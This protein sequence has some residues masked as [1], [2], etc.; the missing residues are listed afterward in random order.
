[1]TRSNQQVYEDSCVEFFVAPSND[2]IYFNFEFNAI[3]TILMGRE[4]A[5]TMIVCVIRL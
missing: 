3:G 1:M 2:G 5:A 4:R